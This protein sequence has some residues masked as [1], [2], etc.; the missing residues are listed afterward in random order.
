MKKIVLLA[1]L[2]VAGLVSA[3]GLEE[4][5]PT[6]NDKKVENTEPVKSEAQKKLLC[7]SITINIMCD[8]SQSFNNSY[9][10]TEGSQASFLEALHCYEQ[11]YTAFNNEICN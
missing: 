7:T 4:I 2:G 11:E 8:A 10:W 6:I 9:C 5:K 1:A 3:K